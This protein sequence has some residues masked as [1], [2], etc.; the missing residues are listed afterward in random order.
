M[1]QCGSHESAAGF[2]LREIHE[3]SSDATAEDVFSMSIDVREL[4]YKKGSRYE[5]EEFHSLKSGGTYILEPATERRDL[6]Q[7]TGIMFYC[8]SLLKFNR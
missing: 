7:Y 1:L 2:V 8:L 4:K 3:V 6:Q 5:F